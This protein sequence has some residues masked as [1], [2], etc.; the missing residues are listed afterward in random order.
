STNI[1]AV[2]AGFVAAA[3]GGDVTIPITF[4]SG[5]DII[6][7]GQRGILPATGSALF[8][9]LYNVYGG[10]SITVSALGTSGGLTQYSPNGDLT[11]T[12]GFTLPAF[13]GTAFTVGAA[14]PTNGA[15][16]ALATKT[17]NTVTINGVATTTS[18][19][20]T[21]AGQLAQINIYNG[22]GFL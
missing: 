15:A 7:K 12:T 9:G 1:V 18:V 14:G 8:G 20:S 22:N 16:V 6:I 17:G 21:P 2:T 19:S 11:S 10:S 13:S 4:S 5:A 3:A